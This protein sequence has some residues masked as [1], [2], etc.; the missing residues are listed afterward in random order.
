MV[1]LKHEAEGYVLDITRNKISKVQYVKY[2]SMFDEYALILYDKSSTHYL[3]IKDLDKIYPY[4]GKD[5]EAIKV[6]YGN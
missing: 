6:L 2:D 5:L 1:K 3:P 4:I